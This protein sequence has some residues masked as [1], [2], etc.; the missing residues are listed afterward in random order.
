VLPELLPLLGDLTCPFFLLAVG[1]TALSRCDLHSPSDRFSRLNK[2]NGVPTLTG[3]LEL[4][5]SSKTNLAPQL[6]NEFQLA[7][8]PPRVFLRLCNASHEPL[9]A[10]GFVSS[11]RFNKR[12][13]TLLLI[14][15]FDPFARRLE[16]LLNLPHE[17]P[18]ASK[19]LQDY[20]EGDTPPVKPGT[21]ILPR[22]SVFSLASL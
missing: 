16:H 1:S 21:S 14:H 10:S 11:C 7:L 6:L 8:P 5:L 4:G 20:G 19:H 15:Q 9:S 22:R 13:P 12:N 18:G 3:L 2:E 17:L